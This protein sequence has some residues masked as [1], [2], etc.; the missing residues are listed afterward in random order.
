MLQWTV[1]VT[2]YRALISF[3][4]YFLLNNIVSANPDYS[5]AQILDELH[6]QV[7]TTLKQDQEGALGR[8]GMDLAFCKIDKEKKTLEFAGAHRPLFQMRN[9]ELNEYRGDRKAIGGIPYNKPKRTLKITCLS[10]RKVIGFSYLVTDFP[11][12]S[13]VLTGKFQVKN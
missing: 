5:A 10:I 8:D 11:T 4:G 6:K 7:R 12:R 9:G 1:R 3:I 2:E 13:V